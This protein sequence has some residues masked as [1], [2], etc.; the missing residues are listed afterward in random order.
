MV[1][2]FHWSCNAHLSLLFSS[3][4]PKICQFYSWEKL[5]HGRF[6]TQNFLF[7]NSPAQR[8]AEGFFFTFSAAWKLHFAN[9]VQQL[10]RQTCQLIEKF[11]SFLQSQ[12]GCLLSAPEFKALTKL[13]CELFGWSTCQVLYLIVHKFNQIVTSRCT[14][15]WDKI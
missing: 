3:N 11:H 15:H 1:F 4:F 8:T 13:C 7:Q 12:S 2:H 10:R 9:K 5:R 14:Y 6:E